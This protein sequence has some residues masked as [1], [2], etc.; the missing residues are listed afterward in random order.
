MTNHEIEKLAKEYCHQYLNDAFR[1][2]PYFSKATDDNE[3]IITQSFKAGYLKGVEAEKLNYKNSIEHEM[4]VV[5]TEY[6]KVITA[7][8][9]DSSKLE[10]QLAIAKEALDKNVKTIGNFMDR[11]SVE[12]IGNPDIST[13]RL[14]TIEAL[15]CFKRSRS[16]LE[17]I[18][19]GDK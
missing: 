18:E 5:R 17:Q 13:A 16:A 1:I 4:A 10:K 6:L 2:E 3:Y 15:H 12:G 14:G 8:V 7:L 9:D 11:L 19:R